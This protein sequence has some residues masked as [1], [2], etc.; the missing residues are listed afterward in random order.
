MNR[1][2]V[3]HVQIT[4]AETVGMEGRPRRV[5][6]DHAGHLRNVIQNHLL[7]ILALV[8]MEP[9][10]TMMARDISDAKLQSCGNCPRGRAAHLAAHWCRPRSRPGRSTASRRTGYRQ[11]EGVA[12][13]LDNGDL[14]GHP[15]DG[16]EAGAWSGVPF[17]AAWRASK[18]H[19]VTEVAVHFPSAAA[20]DVSAPWNARATFATWPPPGPT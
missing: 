4:A 18:S 2:F 19:R 13:R 3:N 14:C 5:F 11:E 1:Q 17:F 12:P 15:H 7:Q 9:P 20:A 8:A 6:Y 10:A 16:G